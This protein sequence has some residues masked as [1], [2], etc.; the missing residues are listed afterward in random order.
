[1]IS[2]VF[3]CGWLRIHCLW[4][5]YT[6]GPW[7][8][9]REIRALFCTLKRSIFWSY[10]RLLNTLKTNGC[11][12]YIVR[13]FFCLIWSELFQVIAKQRGME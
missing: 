13:R 11:Y 4:V 5:C 12:N 10:L 9:L 3:Q 6:E 1:M 8:R 7:C 2:D